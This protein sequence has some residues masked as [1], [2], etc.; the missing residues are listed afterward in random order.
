MNRRMLAIAAIALI[1]ISAAGIGYAATTYTGT[2]YTQ[3][4]VDY[5]QYSIIL[6]N[7]SGAT[8]SSA[9]R[10]DR[11]TY[12]EPVEVAGHYETTV[13]STSDTSD[14]YKLKITCTENSL[15]TRCIVT[16]DDIRSWAIIQS[17]TVSVYAQD[18]ESAPTYT[19][20]L[21]P[22]TESSTSV[23]ID[24]VE[25]PYKTWNADQSPLMTLN[26][27]DNNF[28][29]ITIAYKAVTLKYDSGDDIAFMDLT[30]MKIRFAASTVDP[31]AP[32]VVS[33]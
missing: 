27:A 13:S 4:D 32:E 22:P 21:S 5:Q 16:L 23:T 31:S 14:L 9:I 2:T 15:Q 24:G 25:V 10:F 33:P 1:C 18:S 30:G 17:I 12:T 19:Y 28:V 11:P 6:T 29:R 26:K 3:S 8:I 20:T 7:T